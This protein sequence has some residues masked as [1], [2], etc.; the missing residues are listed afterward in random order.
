MKFRLEIF[1]DIIYASFISIHI[2]CQMVHIRPSETFGYSAWPPVISAS[3]ETHKTSKAKTPMEQDAMAEKLAM[4]SQPD[5]VLLA[6][7]SIISYSFFIFYEI[8]C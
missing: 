2:F 8:S 4:D 5:C 7:C 1:S 6:I 3:K